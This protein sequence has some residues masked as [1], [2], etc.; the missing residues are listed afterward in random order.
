MTKKLI[1]PPQ[2][3]NHGTHFFPH[4][5]EANLQ[6]LERVTREGG[7]SGG[8]WAWLRLGLHYLATQQPQE[9]TYALQCALTINPDDR[10][11]PKIIF[12]YA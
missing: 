9:A 8:G 5:Q 6:L 11:T 3:K 7:R 2:I 1:S 4:L 10:Y 12:F